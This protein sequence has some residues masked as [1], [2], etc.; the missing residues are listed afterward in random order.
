MKW[1]IILLI[2]SG[3]N[4]YRDI[5]Q[6]VQC[7]ELFDCFLDIVNEK[8]CVWAWDVSTTMKMTQQHWTWYNVIYTKNGIAGAFIKPKNVYIK[9]LL[10]LNGFWSNIQL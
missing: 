6:N 9:D 8:K 3:M 4:Y 1:S 2:M 7:K 10:S 5:N